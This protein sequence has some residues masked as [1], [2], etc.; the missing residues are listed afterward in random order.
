M[1]PTDIRVKLSKAVEPFVLAIDIGSTASRGDVYDATGRSLRGGRVKVPHQFTSRSDGTSE[2]DPDAVVSKSN[3]SSPRSPTAPLPGGS[4]Q[5]RWTPSLPHWWAEAADLDGLLL[6][7]PEQRTPLVLPYFTGER[8][9][10]WAAD[11]QAVV[12]GVSAATTGPM[13]FRGI[14]ES[15]A[16]L[17]RQ[18]R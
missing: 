1:T 11:A 7:Q 17:L 15:V 6:A 3:R 13:L 8:S 2:I 16:I 9:T 18:N 12:A 5:W 14:M 4:R 10:G